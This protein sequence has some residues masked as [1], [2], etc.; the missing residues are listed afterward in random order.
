MFQ[1]DAHWRDRT[2]E[3]DKGGEKNVS[4]APGCR[5]TLS[6]TEPPS[7]VSRGAAAE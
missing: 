5:E 4:V 2:P 3:R 6:S 7:T 1:A